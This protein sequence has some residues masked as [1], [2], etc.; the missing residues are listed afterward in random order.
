MLK[1]NEEW[2]VLNSYEEIVYRNYKDRKPSMQI[3]FKKNNKVKVIDCRKSCYVWRYL[4]NFQYHIQKQH[5]I[6]LQ[7]YIFT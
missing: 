3:D 7:G 5:Y 6:F 2:Y 4:I 1:P